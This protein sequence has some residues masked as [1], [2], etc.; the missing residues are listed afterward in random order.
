[1][2]FSFKKLRNFDFG[3]LTLAAIFFIL[4]WKVPFACRGRFR[5]PIVNTNELPLIKFKDVIFLSIW[6]RGHRK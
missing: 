4:A 5:E 1:M 6:G 2:N 3:L